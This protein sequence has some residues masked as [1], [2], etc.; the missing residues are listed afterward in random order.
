M[1][2][3]RG[4]AVAIAVSLGVVSLSHAAGPVTSDSSK[5]V[6]VSEPIVNGEVLT[7]A[8]EAPALQWAERPPDA[9]LTRETDIG[10]DLRYLAH[11]LRHMAD[12][13]DLDIEI[14]SREWSIGKDE[15]LI[16]HQRTFAQ[17]LRAVAEAADARAR[18]IEDLTVQ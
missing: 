3:G 6:A 15:E 16:Q 14:L 13:R 7:K 12:R 18:A 10:S 1:K 8:A 2:F 5:T 17:N 9:G 4:L 11:A